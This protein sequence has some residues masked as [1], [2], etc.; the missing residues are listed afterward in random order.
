MVGKVFQDTITC[1][2]KETHTKTYFKWYTEV[3]VKLEMQINAQQHFFHE[4]DIDRLVSVEIL[5]SLW[6]FVS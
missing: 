3:A 5:G 2:G 1:I 6:I 4:P